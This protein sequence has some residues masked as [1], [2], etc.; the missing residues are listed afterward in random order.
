MKKAVFVKAGQIKITDAPIPQIEAPDDVILKLVRT[1]VC[2]SDLWSFRGI[3]K[4][5]ANSE[6]TG[7]EGIGIVVDT[8]SAIT[9]VKKGDFVIAPFN[10]GCGHCPVCEA[11]YDGN[12][13]SIPMS[14]LWSV[15]YQA[16]YVRFKHGQWAL[17]K[18]PGKPEDYTDA[19]LASFQTLSDV[20]P[21]GYHA[22][23]SAGVSTGDTAII[24]GDGAVGLC[25]VIS[26]KLRGAKRIILM[27]RV[28]QRAE[29]GREFGATDII[30]E[31]DP[32]K[33]VKEA[34]A[35]TDGLGAPAVLECVGSKQ[36]MDEALKM[37]RNGG[38]IA[39]IGVPH[40]A[41]IDS[42][43]LF[44]HNIGIR[45][46]AGAVTTYDKGF[47]LKDV[48]DG[49]INPGKVFTKTYQFDDLQT[50][51]EDM[52]NFKTIKALIKF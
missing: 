6:N 13:V 49:T 48:L 42:A 1:S 22:A 18:I 23:K 52:D 31:Q 10:H 51:Y 29:L 30:S 14:E 15:G 39:R 43:Q 9:T 36:S 2:G 7:H 47:L 27:S 4:K 8:G 33:A 28:A 34:L 44:W 25:A 37:V 3:D 19:M 12:C 35:L 40:D 45:G 50:A 21:T 46:G 5:E 16:E 17:V 20:M 26:C 41:T 11:G 24:L 32:D 38:T